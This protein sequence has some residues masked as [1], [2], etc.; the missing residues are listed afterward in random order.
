MG[1]ISTVE[2]LARRRRLARAP[3]G[4]LILATQPR[5]RFR[6]LPVERPP[7]P[8]GSK[9]PP[10]SAAPPPRGRSA[11]RRRPRPRACECLLPSSSALARAAQAKAALYASPSELAVPC[12]RRRSATASRAHL[13]AAPPRP[14][15]PPRRTGRRARSPPP[16][17]PRRPPTRRSSPALSICNHKSNQIKSEIWATEHKFWMRCLRSAA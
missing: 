16:A 2:A 5:P 11:R 3:A 7:W 4:P 12:A 8:A 14:A 15:P 9:P 10:I 6:F 17:R 13:L 1:Y